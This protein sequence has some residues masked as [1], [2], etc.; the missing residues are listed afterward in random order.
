MTK[1]PNVDIHPSAHEKLKE[2]QKLLMAEGVAPQARLQDI[3]S[4]LIMYTPP[5]QAAGMLAAFSR[6]LAASQKDED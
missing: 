1:Q 6:H 3:A 5:E 2:L 4:A